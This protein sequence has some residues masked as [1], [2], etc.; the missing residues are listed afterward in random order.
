MRRAMLVGRFQPFHNGHLEAVRGVAREWDALIVG[1]GSAYESFT[2]E[3]PFSAGERHEMI[4]GAL[5]EAGIGNVTLLP[6]PD[7]HRNAIWVS[8]VASLAPRFEAFY[9]NNPLPASLFRAAGFDVRPLPF[10]ERA[11]FEGTRIRALMLRGDDEWEKSVPAAVARVA[12]E[13]G[14]VARLRAL[15][16]GDRA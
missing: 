8:H 1:I 6:I 10:V 2:A 11:R 3:N 9:T 16:Q 14:G 15:A 5:A 12:R 4:S 13:V 7:M